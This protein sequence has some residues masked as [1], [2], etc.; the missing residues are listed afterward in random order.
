M[1]HIGTITANPAHCHLDLPQNATISS[2]L[3]QLWGWIQVTSP[4]TDL[5][6]SALG[7]AVRHAR[8]VR[9][10]L[11]PNQHAGFSI[12]LDLSALI[13]QGR[14]VPDEMTI[15]C[16]DGDAPLCEFTVRIAGV[17][18]V[19]LSFQRRN[20]NK[21]SKFLQRV[22]G[23]RLRAWEGCRAP[24]AL[25]PDWE[26]SPV[27]ADKTD[28]VSSHFYGPTVQ[29][30]LA[31]LD[32][33][34]MILD[35][36]AGFRKLPYRNVI[37]LEIY[38]YPS[39]DV[40]ATA[41]RLPF[42][43]NCFDAVLSLAVLE[44]VRDPFACAREIA[45]VL[46]PGGKVLAMIP[47]LQAEHGYPSHYFNATRFGVQ[48]LFRGMDMDAQFME[49]SNQPI[50]TLHQILRLYAWGLP[51]EQQRAFLSLTIASIINRAPHDWL[52]DPLVTELSQEAAWTVAWG[53]TSVFTKK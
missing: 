19:D 24:S 38:D 23:D 53:T 15:M 48:E 40:L 18:A 20:R 45:R 44:H 33:E 21:K 42:P 4:V 31:G 51:A 22:C 34:A 9:P 29:K 2:P 17:T 8:I 16:L 6:F 43:D 14:E 36:G 27:L 46:K 30:F 5:R 47:F 13:P 32:P 35:A 1:G 52:T 26:V 37:N 39:T 3:D 10:N 28:P 25:P 50:F 41:D 12:F 49:A 11:D 7:Q